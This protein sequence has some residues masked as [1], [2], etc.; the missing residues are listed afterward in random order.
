[1][2]RIGGSTQPFGKGG[3]LRIG[4]QPVKKVSSEAISRSE[5]ACVEL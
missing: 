2:Q 5:H 4:S 1:M 3:T